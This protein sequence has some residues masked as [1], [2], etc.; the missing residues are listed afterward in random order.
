MTPA[1]SSSAPGTDLPAECSDRLSLPDCS[2][3]SPKLCPRR[4]TAPSVPCAAFLPQRCLP[5]AVPTHVSLAVANSHSRLP[6]DLLLSTL[7]PAR[8]SASAHPARDSN[9]NPTTWFAI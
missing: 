9:R 2:P 8:C 3:P 6:F 4:R 1:S 7:P 5:P